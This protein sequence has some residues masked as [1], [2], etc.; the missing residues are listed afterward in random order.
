VSLA[1]AAVVVPPADTTPPEALLRL[2]PHGRTAVATG[3]DPDGG[4][5]RVRVSIEERVSCRNML[6][7]E[8]SRVRRIRYFPPP[9]IARVKVTPGTR[10]PAER[11]RSATLPIAG[12]P[13]PGSS[14]DRIEG[15]VRADVT[16]AHELEASSPSRRYTRRPLLQTLL[17]VLLWIS[18]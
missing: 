13:C 11:R 9:A 6:T 16:N 15:S 3:R 18:P 17:D 10:L 14:V 2:D 5:A 8:R 1:V 7:G 4:V 12:D